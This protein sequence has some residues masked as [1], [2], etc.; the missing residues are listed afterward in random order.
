MEISVQHHFA[1]INGI[2][3]HYVSKGE[4]ELVILLHGFPEF[5]YSWRHQIEFLSKDFKV[6]ALDMRGYNESDKPRGVANY[7]SELLTSDVDQLIQHLGYEKANIIG[8]DWGGA[9]SWNFAHYYP[10]RVNRIAVLNCPHPWL[11]KKNFTF[12]QFLRSWYTFYFQI[13]WLPET[14]IRLLLKSFLRFAFQHYAKNK[15]AFTDAD[16]N[17]Y[18][19]ALRKPYS[20]AAGIHY[21][22]AANNR[23]NTRG[24]KPVKQIES[25]ALLIWALNDHALDISMTKN[26]PPLFKNYF[27]IKFIPHCSH[28]V[29]N[30]RPD[31]V[32]EML[33][34]FLKTKF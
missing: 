29:Q 1:K 15:N 6:V 4:G 2:H 21:Y 20:I 9:V 31:T 30:D 16:I 10:H 14:L 18:A 8:H 28:W 32:N 3:L 17:R 27:E 34:E 12:R 26:H 25:P 24:M 11:F 23:L 22:R 5:W 33:G 13:P 7:R 19:E